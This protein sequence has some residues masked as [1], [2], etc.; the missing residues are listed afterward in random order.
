[1]FET[2]LTRY[3]RIGAARRLF[4]EARLVSDPLSHPELR[5]M[6]PH[7]LADIP[8]PRGGKGKGGGRAR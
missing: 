7:E 1:M 2:L 8:F 3:P 6:R 4:E 5:R